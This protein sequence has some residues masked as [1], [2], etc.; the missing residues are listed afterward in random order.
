[1]KLGGVYNGDDAST[2]VN[3]SSCTDHSAEE[4]IT[5]KGDC[6]ITLYTDQEMQLQM[7]CQGKKQ[8]EKIFQYKLQT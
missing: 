1:M 5:Q 3:E 6:A 2:S 8:S 4:D 7:A